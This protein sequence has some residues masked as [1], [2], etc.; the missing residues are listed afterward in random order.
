MPVE[1]AN[2]WEDG[3]QRIAT[4][5][6]LHLT[7]NDYSQ[8]GVYA[9]AVAGFWLDSYDLMPNN[10]QEGAAILAFYLAH[11]FKSKYRFLCL[12]MKTGE[13]KSRV[14]AQSLVMTLKCS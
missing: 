6:D 5:N 9:N 12:V 8:M 1:E 3:I 2:S 10:R 11:H 4:L 13:G 7:K 14:A